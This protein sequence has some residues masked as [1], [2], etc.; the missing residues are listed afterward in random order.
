MWTPL[1]SVPFGA[2]ASAGSVYDDVWMLSVVSASSSFSLRSRTSAMPIVVTPGV[3]VPL[4]QVAAGNPARVRTALTADLS[5]VMCAA[6][7]GVAFEGYSEKVVIVGS[8]VKVMAVPSAMLLKVDRQL[9]WL[10]AVHPCKG[11]RYHR[12]PN[13]S[14]F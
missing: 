13:A 11:T 8:V 3:R 7:I 2:P 5:S 14:S 9:P 12:S 1:I 4:V 10:F 6:L